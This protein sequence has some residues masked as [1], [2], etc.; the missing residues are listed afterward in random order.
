MENLEWSPRSI[1]RQNMKYPFLLLTAALASGILIASALPLTLDAIL[2]GAA[3]LGGASIMAWHFCLVRSSNGKSSSGIALARLVCVISLF[4]A[5]GALAWVISSPP[6][7]DLT[8]ARMPVRAVIQDIAVLTSGDRIIADADGQIVLVR[9]KASSVRPGDIVVLPPRFR[10]VGDLPNMY[11]EEYTER[12]RAQGIEYEETVS[13]DELVV[14][15]RSPALNY[16]AREIRDA[17]ALRIESL[18]LRKAT[19]DFLITLF[20]GEKNVIDSNVRKKFSDA[21][22]SHLLA[23]SGMHVSIVVGII[24]WLL[25]PI[26]FAGLWRWRYLFAAILLWVYTWIT[27]MAPST[28]RASLM[29]T[30]FFAAII[31]QR[32]GNAL[33]TL[34]AAAFVI[35]IFSPESIRDIGAQLSF[36]SVASLIIFVNPLNRVSHR[37]HPRLYALTGALL[38]SMAAFAATWPLVSYHFGR[39]PLL[40]LPV[41][42]IAL[43]LLPFYMGLALVYFFS[44]ALGVELEFMRHVL[45]WGFQSLVDLSSL[46]SGS[47]RSVLEMQV[48][49]VTVL[50]WCMALAFAAI[51]F[52][53]SSPKLRKLGRW[54]A[55]VSAILALGGCCLPVREAVPRGIIVQSYLNGINILHVE[56]ESRNTVTLPRGKVS[57][58]ISGNIKIVGVD[59][60]PAK[61]DSAADGSHRYDYAIIASGYK[62]D[63]AHLIQN[64]SADT[65]VF[66]PTI[67]KRR[68]QMLLEEARQ[69]G[70]PAHSLRQ[71]GPLRNISLSFDTE[72]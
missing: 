52:L 59:S 58:F 67:N 30:F 33:N 13:G 32:R 35:L 27:G 6:H 57:G 55:S 47:G 40:F 5:A 10:R 16:K 23:L 70:L 22:I 49:V 54:G 4:S 29:A 3:A 68:E 19:C 53:S 2:W 36:L 14:A 62:G 43:P 45:D 65:V 66:H 37:E 50:L 15:G 18:P 20:L 41:N 34:A 72:L 56:G 24:L 48:G 38:T 8:E 44:C 1:L 11:M 63:L 9:C 21:G 60:D 25:F 31:M 61:I 12:M 64:I 46:V 39:V 28:V 51:W 26:N 42:I 7:R 69:I 17:L 71:H